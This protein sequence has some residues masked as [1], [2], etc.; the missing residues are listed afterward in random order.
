[1]SLDKT[2]TCHTAPELMDQ[3]LKHD[4][5]Q[6][7]QV[8]RKVSGRLIWFLFILFVF[9][10]LDRINIGFAGLTMAKSLNLTA[11]M[12]GFAATIFT[13]PTCCAASPAT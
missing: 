9:S 5:Q 10:F 12:F 7:Q 6:E 4:T 8:I 3:A 1:M 2:T 11:T 13:S